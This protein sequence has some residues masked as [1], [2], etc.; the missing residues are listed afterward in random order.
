MRE[1]EGQ[2]GEKGGEEELRT[3][4]PPSVHRAK[5]SAGDTERRK[6]EKIERKIEHWRRSEQQKPLV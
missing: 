3:A 6:E 4:E 2:G 1:R 5:N